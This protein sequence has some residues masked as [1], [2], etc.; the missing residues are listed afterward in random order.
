[1]THRL[2]CPRGLQSE[3]ILKASLVFAAQLV[4][5]LG[6]PCLLC[7]WSSW[8]S[9]QGSCVSSAVPPSYLQQHCPITRVTHLYVFQLEV[10]S[11]SITGQLSS[12]RQRSHLGNVQIP[13]STLQVSFTQK[14]KDTIF[15]QENYFALLKFLINN[16]SRMINIGG[17]NTVISIPF[18]PYCPVLAIS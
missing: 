9:F 15:F 13:M 8:W 14:H 10:R 4:I 17:F 6:F 5:F 2:L 1:M 12:C 11:L 7:H 16:Q 3:R 18:C